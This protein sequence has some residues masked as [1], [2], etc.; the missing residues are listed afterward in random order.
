MSD[1]ST[2]QYRKL[3]SEIE[4]VSS[5]KAIAAEAGMDPARLSNLLAGRVPLNDYC[6]RQLS[7]ICRA[8]M[9]LA[10]RQGWSR[11]EVWALNEHSLLGIGRE[12][13]EERVLAEIAARA[14]KREAVTA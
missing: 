3:R 13:D 10:W 14:E 11:A 7:A 6:L 8:L 1:I 4:L 9:V 2:E 12:L 5:Q